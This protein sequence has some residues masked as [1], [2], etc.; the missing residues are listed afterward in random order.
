VGEARLDLLVGQLLVVELK[1]VESIAP[2]HIA[3]VLSYLRT[4][5]LRLGLLINFNVPQLRQGIKRI[6]H[7]P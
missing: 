1:S 7:T 3:Q 6:I 2:I 4:T 5:R